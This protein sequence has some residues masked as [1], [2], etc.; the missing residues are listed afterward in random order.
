MRESF[1]PRVRF[2]SAILL[3]LVLILLSR[4]YL[5][6]IVRG[7]TYNQKA[8]RQYIAPN[9]GLF[10]RGT[11]FYEDKNQKLISAATIKTGYSLVLNTKLLEDSFKAHSE[12]EKIVD[13]DDEEFFFKAGKIND[14]YEVVLNKLPEEKALA[15]DNLNIDGIQVFKEKWRFYPG[16]DVGAQ[17]LGF[18]GSSGK[19]SDGR[20][21]LERYYEDVLKRGNSTGEINFFAEIFSNIKKGF[22]DEELRREGDIVTTI[23]P[24]VQTFFQTRINKVQKEWSSDLT[25]GLILNPKTG[26]IFAMAVAPSFNLNEFGKVKDISIFRNPI[27]EDVYEMGSI[28]K[29]LTISAGLDSES[30]TAETTYNDKGSKEI[31]GYEISNYDEEA[32]G[33][34]DMQEV[35]SQSLNLGVVFAVE[36]MGTD[37]F[38]EYMKDFGL[39][40]KTDIDL[41]NEAAPLIHN[42]ESP[43]T[44]E[45]ATASFGQGIALSPIMTVRALSAIANDG[46][47]TSPHLVKRINY[48]IG[49]P[50]ET[51]VREGRQVLKK[52]TADEITRMLVRVVDEALAGGE[53]KLDN[54]SVAA[55]TGT[56]QIANPQ[57]KGY[58]DDRFLHSFFGYF[59]AYDP[60]FMVFLYTVHPKEV[61][62]ASQTLTEPFMDVTK[63]LINYY[64]IPPDR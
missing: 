52:E 38:S 23:E 19:V 26:E 40:E 4:L 8:D 47:L 6:Q 55:K 15:I 48:D 31:D 50:K 32:R 28:I 63:F 24:S 41:P 58:Y 20:Y 62:Y 36:K 10:E 54:Y 53:V 27:I 17:M 11:I 43:R 57:E 7:E 30:I 64:E 44:I 61:R 49:P 18:V 5:V 39:T 1:L 56:A 25:A 33:I 14:P 21:G 9:Q 59:P 34:V 37:V 60:E 12:I 2:V 22:G 13:V 16:E 45:Y 42:L 3:L 51:K 46:V 35:L 29:P